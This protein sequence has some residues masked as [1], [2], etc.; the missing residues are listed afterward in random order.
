MSEIEQLKLD[1]KFLLERAQKAGSCSFGSEEEG[2][3]TGVSSNSI[4]AIAYGLTTK[5]ELPWDIFDLAAC[6]RMWSK[7]PAHRKTT[8]AINAMDAA[9]T[10]VA[11]RLR[12][13]A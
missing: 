11:K 13:A 3:E 8:A 9:E 5:Q 7:L 4:V 1:V 2:R 6:R 10:F 12:G